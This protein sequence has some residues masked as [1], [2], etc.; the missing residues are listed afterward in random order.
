MATGRIPINGTA[1]IQSTIVDA[2]GDIIAATAADAVSRLAV[3]ANNTVLTADSSTATG[4]KWAAAAAGGMTVLA[5]GTLSSTAV[6]LSS[7]SQSYKD[8]QLVI[9][10]PELVASGTRLALRW[11]GITSN[12]YNYI[13]RDG[14]TLSAATGKDRLWASVSDLS[15]S[16][17]VSHFVYT[18]ADYTSATGHLIYGIGNEVTSQSNNY[19]ATNT[20][21]SPAAITEIII[22]TQ[23]GTSTFDGGTYILYGV[24]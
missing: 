21:G 1:A 19:W 6:T 12:T 10:S 18:F 23:S 17:N 22:T 16:A 15:L 5:S 9:R 20:A 14:S 24:S 2:K 4:L 8:L 3:G 13:W 7:I 11:N